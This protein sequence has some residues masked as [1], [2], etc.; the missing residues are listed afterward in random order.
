[1]TIVKLYNDLVSTYRHHILPFP[2]LYFSSLPLP[3]PLP[4][5]SGMM[6]NSIIEKVMMWKAAGLVPA[7]QQQD[8]KR[9]EGDRPPKVC[10]SWPTSSSQV[11]PPSSHH[12]QMMPSN[13][14]CTNG[15]SSRWCQSHPVRTRGKNGSGDV[16]AILSGLEERMGQREEGQAREGDT[17]AWRWSKYITHMEDIIK[18]QTY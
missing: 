11:S 4:V 2:L 9:P 10:L 16:R 15:W 14:D 1:M 8:Q 18:K 12:L 6:W 13:R 5:V 3:S 17:A 7:R